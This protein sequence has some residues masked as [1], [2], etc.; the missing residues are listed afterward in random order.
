MFFLRRKIYVKKGIKKYRIDFE[1][2]KIR[3]KKYRVDFEIFSSLGK[4]EM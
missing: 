2:W 1:M 4:K 3:Y